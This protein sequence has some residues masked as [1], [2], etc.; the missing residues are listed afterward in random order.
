MPA[1]LRLVLGV[2]LVLAGVALVTVAVLGARSMLP[3]NRWAGV[4]TAATLESAP[5]WVSANQVAAPPLGAAGAVCLFAGVVLLAGPPA[6]LGWIVTAIGVVGALV[7]AG[8]GGALGDRAGRIETATRAAEA[9]A[10]PAGGCTGSCAGC[11][12]VAG[13]R[14]ASR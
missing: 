6:A 11:D 9:A 14:T 2:L 12:L 8:I 1:T 13:C 7:L 5:A 10:G 3:R 4:R